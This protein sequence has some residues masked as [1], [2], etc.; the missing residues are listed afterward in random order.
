MLMRFRGL[1]VATQIVFLSALLCSAIFFGFTCFV[2]WSSDRAAL[3]QAEGDLR[4]QLK[5]I[6]AALDFAYN[7]ALAHSE[8]DMQSFHALLKQPV[9]ADGTL[10]RT[11]DNPN[12]PTLK[13]GNEVLNGNTRVLEEVRRSFGTEP[14][15]LVIRDGKVVRASTLLKDS[16][17]RSMMGTAL[18]ADDP[19]AVAVLKGER[20][21]GIAI[22]FGKMYMMRT[23]PIRDDAG[24]PIGAA[25]LRVDLASE[26]GGIK[27]ALKKIA[28]GKT[29]YVFA[30]TPTNDDKIATFMLHP[31][32][33]GTTLGEMYKDSPENRERALG[34]IRNHGGVSLYDFADKNDNGRVKRKIAVYE[35]MP[36]LKWMVGTG[37]FVE[38]FEA[39]YE[40]H[41]T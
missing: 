38:E 16:E 1:P 19:V 13:L 20:Y 4:N 31:T 14:A 30:Y 23:D 7:T 24:H 22:R 37:S 33:E 28:V 29:G 9:T 26:I 10:T 34:I 6:E 12:V 41:A 8:R 39:A 27:E 11:G 18:A 21:A 25:S 32:L 2:S 5:V 35:Y 17:G 36:N 15:F 40:R 3:R